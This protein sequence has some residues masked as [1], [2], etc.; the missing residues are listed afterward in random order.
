MDLSRR[1]TVAIVILLLAAGVIAATT[2]TTPVTDNDDGT[3]LNQPGGPTVTLV[4]DTEIHNTSGGSG[5][6]ITWDTAD[7]SVSFTS[8]AS[9]N[10]TINTT[11][12]AGTWTTVSSID[13][14]GAELTINPEDKK[15]VTVGDSIE[16]VQFREM[17]LDDD[18]VDFVYRGPDGNTGEVTVRGLAADT[19][20]AAVDSDTGDVLETSKTNASGVATL[21]ELP[22][23]EHS[24]KLVSSA[25][26]PILSDP[27]PNGNVSTQPADLSVHVD[28]DEFPGDTVT[29]E[30]F[31]DKSKIDT[32]AA[33]NDG[34]YSTT[35]V[36]SFTG[37]KEWSVI[38]T[39]ENGNQDIVNATVGV[40]GTLYIRN[41]TNP[42]ELV[43]DPINVSVRFHD[44]EIVEKETNDGTIDMSGLPTTDFIVEIEPTGNF[45]DRTVY[46]PSIVG[47][48]DIYLLNTSSKDSIDTRFTLNDPTAN[49][50]DTSILY[51]QKPIEQ[52]GTIKYRT[53][54]ADEFGVEGVTA[55]L[56]EDKRYRIVVQAPDGTTQDI[57]PYRSDVSETVEIRPGSPAVEIDQYDQGWGSTAKLD[58][59]VIEVLF[60]DPEDSTTQVTVYIHEKGNKSNRLRANQ[61]FFN[62]GTF[63]AQYNLDANETDKVWVVNLIIDRDDGA[64][65]VSRHEVGNQGNLVLPDLSKEWRLIIGMAM[66]FLFAGAFSVLNATAG[67][68]M[69]GVVGG[70]LWWTGW[71]T[72]ATMGAA[73]VIYLFVAV[74]FTIYKSGGP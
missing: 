30:F 37:A 64:Q 23:S 22:T 56:E 16:Y 59:D 72:D 4:G 62:L 20:I 24:V 17:S 49:F 21:A 51:I 31:F 32:V 28:D 7:G 48:R 11:D 52:G 18:T 44:G 6:T 40:P 39:D 25:A 58:E 54:H 27:R 41:E 36:P 46:F 47:Q 66:L 1:R 42:S 13:T 9:T 65:H 10:A 68:I 71:L 67:G 3:V 33:T 15:A 26:A 63:S 61:T 45:S 5:D 14:N 2:F 53:V 74:L 38:A 57:G 34:R 43:D 70:L 55:T 50:P 69:F 60:D 73:V 29:L 19:Q 12:I 35:N 8:A